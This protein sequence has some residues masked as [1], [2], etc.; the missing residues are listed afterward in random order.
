MACMQ[1]ISL[2]TYYVSLKCLISMQ[3][4]L[5][6]TTVDIYEIDACLTTERHILL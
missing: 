2:F 1:F 6:P 5:V 4:V 3:Y